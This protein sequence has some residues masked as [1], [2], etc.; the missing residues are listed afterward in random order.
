MK[1]TINQKSDGDRNGHDT[2]EV[3]VSLEDAFGTV[4]E[5][6]ATLQVTADPRELAFESQVEALG[7]CILRRGPEVGTFVP[8]ESV[9]ILNPV[10]NI[11]RATEYIKERYGQKEQAEQMAA[12]LAPS[13]NTD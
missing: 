7:Q 11:A 1:L 10:M 2:R 3:T 9:A 8:A 12:N 13:E 6:P 4:W 5:F